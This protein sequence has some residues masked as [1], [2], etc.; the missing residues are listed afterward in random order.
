MKK[1]IK[2]KVQ[3]PECK[4]LFDIPLINHH[5]IDYY[6]KKYLI[7]ICGFDEKEVE[8]LR[9][10]LVV[11]LCRKCEQEKHKSNLFKDYLKKSN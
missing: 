3:C 8:S 4:R 10:K 9:R 5:L 11:K 6:F 2:F 1:K 7:V